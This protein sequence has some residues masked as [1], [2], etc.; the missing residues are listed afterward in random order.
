[1]KIIDILGTKYKVY[2]DVPVD[3]DEGLINRFGYT[4][5]LDRKIVIVDLNTIDYWNKE[6]DEVKRTQ[7]NDTLRHEIIHAFVYESGLWGSSLG[8]DA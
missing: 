2:T 1:M 8:V 7:V 5:C 3:K 4:S 6:S